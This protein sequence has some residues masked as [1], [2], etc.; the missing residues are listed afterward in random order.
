LFS[1]L[2]G[3]LQIAAV[4]LF[5][6]DPASTD[7]QPF[8]SR[9]E[10]NMRFIRMLSVAVLISLIVCVRAHA[11]GPTLTVISDV[12]YRANGSP[13]SGQIIIT[14]QGFTTADGY[15]VP[16]GTT[17]LIIPSSGAISLLL[18]PNAGATPAGSYYKATYKL[19][20]GTSSTEYWVV[21]TTSPTT[22]AAIRSTLMPS[23]VAV[24]FVSSTQLNQAI[25]TEDGKVV[26][27]TG[28]ETVGGNKTFSSP[29]TVPQ[30][31]S[32]L[33][34]GTAPFSIASTTPVN[35]LS[36]GGGAGTSVNSAS[37]N[38]ELNA[39]QYPGADISAQV[40]SAMAV[41][42][43]IHVPAGSY[44][45]SNTLTCNQA[46]VTIHAEGVTLTYTGTGKAVS[47]A[48]NYCTIEGLTLIHNTTAG[49]SI[50]IS[51]EP[52]GL[53]HHYTLKN[54]TVEG[55]AGNQFYDNILVSGAYYG[56][57]EATD[58]YGA[59]N[60]DY[61]WTNG[62]NSNNCIACAARGGNSSTKLSPYGFL[63]DD[64]TSNT[65]TVR[66]LGGTAEGN[67]LANV[68]IEG[69]DNV[70]VVGAHLEA[71]A[72]VSLG[73]VTF[74]NGSTAI[75]SSSLFASTDVGRY[76]KAD[77]DAASDWMR[78]CAYVNPN[79]ETLC[80]NYQ[81]ASATG[82]ASFVAA[83]VHVVN[84]L[85]AAIGNS[86]VNTLLTT[87][88]GTAP[89][90]Y[91]QSGQNTHLDSGDIAMPVILGAL[92][93]GTSI[94]AGNFS[95]GLTD[96]EVD[97]KIF[98]DTTGNRY[99]TKIAGNKYFDLE[100][101]GM[102][103]PKGITTSG[104]ITFGANS[105]IS[106]PTGGTGSWQF[107]AGSG[108]NQ[109]IFFSSTANSILFTNNMALGNSG[110]RWKGVWSTTGDFSSTVNATGYE[111][112][113]VA[114]AASNLSNGTTGSGSMVLAT[115]PTLVAPT[116]TAPV[117]TSPVLGVASATS[118]AINGGHAMSNPPTMSFNW[119]NNLTLGSGTF[120]YLVLPYAVTIKRI[121]V[122]LLGADPAGCT[123]P[124]TIGMTDG[125]T[126]S[127][128]VSLVNSASFDD[129][130]AITQNYAAGATLGIVQTAGTGC[131]NQGAGFNVLVQYQMQ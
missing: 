99:Y 21:P 93:T 35:N 52:G 48:A 78:V 77:A 116:L 29:V 31:I 72:P 20:D 87:S 120:N 118:L 95:G 55:S 3:R 71:S 104:S 86:L 46:A 63:I 67:T 1:A 68:E 96:L 45:A 121:S 111:V 85:T 76:I 51:V 60:A 91:V 114:L 13:A 53:G 66:I 92:P 75:T 70:T 6:C 102:D 28:D 17:S 81:G 37:V 128:A 42:S 19:S 61:H 106:A 123:T 109:N 107:A 59:A 57:I 23:Q 129:S 2:A 65:D 131:T 113:G 22:I 27:T 26:H 103:F 69:A 39:A 14:W 11:S 47:I 126:V 36:L 94:M 112:G 24:Q 122:S 110:N 43:V 33:P 40:N 82:S 62:A 115:S 74:S 30:V 9:G 80:D 18:A 56:Q 8:W 84:G 41:N 49:S 25:A 50:G 73:T 64:T 54:V 7:L 100:S 105:T 98:G 97:S 79:S 117:M 125:T 83:D 5:F 130:G 88:S 15:A 127:P 10:N 4:R 90:L 89:G 119:Y 34:T 58:S 44:M 38:G 108:S 16:A 101:S 12:V 32:T 124:P